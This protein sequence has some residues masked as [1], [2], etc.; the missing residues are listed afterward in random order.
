MLPY[1]CEDMSAAELYYE[2]VNRTNFVPS[3]GNASGVFLTERENRLELGSVAK[4]NDA[5]ERVLQ[6]VPEQFSRDYYDS[7]K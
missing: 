5:V 2:L 3:D 1:G 4:F 6:Q 7:K